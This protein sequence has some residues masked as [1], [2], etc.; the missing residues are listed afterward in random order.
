MPLARRTPAIALQWLRIA[1]DQSWFPES[2]REW[3]AEQR[4]ALSQAGCGLSC[5][6]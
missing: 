5:Q 1:L 2:I 3:G 4:V 6:R